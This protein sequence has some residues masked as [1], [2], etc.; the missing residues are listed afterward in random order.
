MIKDSERLGLDYRVLTQATFDFMLK[1]KQAL[2]GQDGKS[3]R[4]KSSFKKHIS[5]Q[6]INETT[7]IELMGFDD[8]FDHLFMKFKIHC[9]TKDS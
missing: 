2:I 4:F 9:P 5:R 7:N 6:V 8:L 1:I 3:E